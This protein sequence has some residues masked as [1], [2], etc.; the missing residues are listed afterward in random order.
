MVVGPDDQSVRAFRDAWP[1]L[2][3]A[4]ISTACGKTIGALLMDDATGSRWNF[5][6]CAVG[7]AKGA[8]LEPST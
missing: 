4:R 8:C 1:G 7:K 6:G 2:H 3:G 5:Q